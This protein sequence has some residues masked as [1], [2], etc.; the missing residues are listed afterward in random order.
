MKQFQLRRWHENAASVLRANQR[1]EMLVP[2]LSGLDE[3]D[4]ARRRWG[5]ERRSRCRI[6]SHGPGSSC[7]AQDR[8]YIDFETALDEGHLGSAALDL[9]IIHLLG[10]IDA[11]QK[12][13][14]LVAEILV[15]LAIFIDAGDIKNHVNV[16]QV[17]IDLLQYIFAKDPALTTFVTLSLIWPVIRFFSSATR[18]S[19]CA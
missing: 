17:I 9:E 8:D 14:D 1:P 6:A 19:T 7:P 18:L 12:V 15:R 10:G 5:Y 3:L 2:C 11:D 16:G 13:I 4:M